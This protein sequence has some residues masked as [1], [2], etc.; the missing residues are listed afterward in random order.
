MD[1]PCLVKMCTTVYCFLSCSSV[2]LAR[3]DD[4]LLTGLSRHTLLNVTDCG[5]YFK[6]I[7][8]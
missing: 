1:W 5:L 2:R 6:T 4:V 3:G 8:M 7:M